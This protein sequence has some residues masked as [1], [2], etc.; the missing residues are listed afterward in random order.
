MIFVTSFFVGLSGTLL[1]G[2][3]LTITIAES[4]RHGVS[5]GAAMVLGH[6]IAELSLVIAL[7]T[8]LSR[9]LGKDLVTAGVSLVGGAFL[10]WMS[11]GI[12]GAALGPLDP[13]EGG[14]AQAASPYSLVFTGIAASL[15]NPTW[16][17]WWAS[18]G[19]TYVLSSLK[20]GVGG[21]ASFYTGH[22]LADSSWYLLVSFVVGAGRMFAVGLVY[23]IILAACGAFLIVLGLYFLAG[24]ARVLVK[25]LNR[26]MDAQDKHD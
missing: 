21:L 13:F 6:G 12:L 11:L 15:F 16:L 4:A 3:F 14:Q 10:L 8:G 19:T 25:M 2:P 1:P 7:A 26:N 23:R 22:I 5:A 17:I 20:N 9:V 18:I 24:G